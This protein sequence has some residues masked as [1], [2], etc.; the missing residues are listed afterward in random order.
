MGIHPNSLE[1]AIKEAARQNDPVSRIASRL[2]RI[3]TRFLSAFIKC[4]QILM[5]IAGLAAFLYGAY[6]LG[7][8]LW[9][10]LKG[11]PVAGHVVGDEVTDE[12]RE[13]F[14]GSSKTSSDETEYSDVPVYRPTIRYR[15]PP[16]NGEVYLHR[17]SVEFEGDEMDL[18][19]IGNRVTIRVLPEAP[20][21][22]RLPGGFTHYLWAG[23]GLAAGLFAL[24]LVSSLFFMYESLF[25]R[26]LSKGLSLFRSLNWTAT[27][28]VLLALAVGLQQFHQRVVPCSDSRN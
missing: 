21:Y 11:V 19:G 16:E 12:T 13:T 20:D 22:A 26:D 8:D 23:I 18:Y 27:V 25:G 7:Q 24:V 6:E 28:L 3:P 10:S 2:S 14:A 5:L 1:S 15:W 4:T 9:F 17:S